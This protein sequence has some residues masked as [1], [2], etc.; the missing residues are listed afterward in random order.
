MME[1]LLCQIYDYLNIGTAPQ[2]ADCIFVLAGRQERKIFGIQLWQQAYAPEVILSVARFE[3][4]KFYHLGLSADGGLKAM[5]DQT[6]PI[7]RHFFVRTN[8]KDASCQ[9]VQPGW[10]GTWREARALAAF[11]KNDPVQSL[12]VISDAVHLRRVAVAFR[13]A[14]RRRQL[15]LTFVAVAS[16]SQPAKRHSWWRESESRGYVLKEFIKYLAYRTIF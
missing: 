11:L 14:F 7:R 9:W 1:S 5:V 10:F 6:P 4:R 2:K 3:W 16:E 15:K 12:M 8:G 13:R